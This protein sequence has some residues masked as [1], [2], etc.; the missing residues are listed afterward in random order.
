MPS[1]TA[2]LLVVATPIGNLG[3]LS[4]RARESLAAA[5][6]VLAEDTRVAGRLFQLG[7]I[8]AGRMMSLFEH[9]EAKRCREVL[10]A[11]S[12]G[13]TAALISSAGTP[14]ISDPGYRIVR[15]CRDAG[16]PVVPVP[17]PSAPITALMASGLPPYP[18]TFLGF[19]PRKKG[20]KK[21]AL[22]PYAGLKST[23][24]FFERKSRLA[25]TLEVAFE[26]LG[27]REACLARELTKQH[28]EFMLFSLGE[29]VPGLSEVKGE[30]T[31]V[32]GPPAEHSSATSTAEVQELIFRELARGGRPRDI[33]SRVQNQVQGWVPK[34]LY[35]MIE[36]LKA[37]GG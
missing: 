26:A 15:A 14:L 31:V 12:Q 11:L 20:D 6:L 8:E 33:V 27:S 2:K 35:T 13:H 29:A 10:E 32:L 23:L 25:E 7:G 22:L 30:V 16:Y 1:S 28:E 3:D 36:Q 24:V 37:Q 19:L 34:D 17:G 4:D 21:K 5:D 18:F 9:N